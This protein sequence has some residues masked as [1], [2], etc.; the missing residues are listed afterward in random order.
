MT[1]Y[2]RHDKAFKFFELAKYQAELFSKDQY[3]KVGALFLAPDSLQILT[4][5]FNGFPRGIDETDPKRWERP[6]K[7]YRV[8]HAE[9]NGI[10]NASRRGTP[11]ENSICVVT[12]FPCSDCARALIQVGVKMIVTAEPDFGHV[13]H[14]ETYRYAFD[15]LS[16]AKIEMLFVDSTKEPDFKYF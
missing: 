11:L 10:Y 7:N 16:E 12:S 15:M 1:N 13:R 8:E 6:V 2:I 9:R 5:S 14:G 4:S 3:K